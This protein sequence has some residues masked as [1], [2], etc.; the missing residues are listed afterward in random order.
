MKYLINWYVILP[1]SLMP[2]SVL[3]PEG[4]K[5]VGLTKR[6][7]GETGTHFLLKSIYNV[8]CTLVFI[9]LEAMNEGP[10]HMLM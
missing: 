4:I 5:G 6:P 3:E 8:S 9:Y 1:P 10:H 7:L 2:V